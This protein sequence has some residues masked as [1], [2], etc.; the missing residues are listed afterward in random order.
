MPAPKGREWKLERA[1]VTVKERA[2]PRSNKYS[3]S[4]NDE[5]PAPNTRTRYWIGGYTR[6]DGTKVKGHYREARA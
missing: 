6:S 1:S 2:R 4:D 3:A 5:K